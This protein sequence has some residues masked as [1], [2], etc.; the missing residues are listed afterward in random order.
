M[1]F[2]KETKPKKPL[3]S[4]NAVEYYTQ[5]T[6]RFLGSRVTPLSEMPLAYSKPC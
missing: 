1:P 5:N 4:T 2:N 3:A 6:P